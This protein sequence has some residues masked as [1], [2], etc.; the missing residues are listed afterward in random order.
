MGKHKAIITVS[1]TIILSIALVFLLA[2]C[3]SNKVTLNFRTDY[4]LEAFTYQLDSNHPST[5]WARVNLEDGMSKSEA[6]LVAAKV[7]S[8]EMI[9]IKFEIKSATVDATG[10]WTENFSR[11]NG[12]EPFG[13]HFNVKINPFHQTVTYD[14]CW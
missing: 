6:I 8:Q 7:S 2:A 5:V 9:N 1:F 13:Y 11:G 4:E 12:Q 3:L 14:R 10:V